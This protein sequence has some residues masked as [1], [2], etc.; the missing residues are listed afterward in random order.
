MTWRLLFGAGA[1]LFMFRE[2]LH[3]IAGLGA[4]GGG[5]INFDLKGL[6]VNRKKNPTH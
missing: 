1:M 6:G 3:E 4:R 2:L 5:K